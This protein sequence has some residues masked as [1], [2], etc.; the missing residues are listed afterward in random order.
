MKR[1]YYN[2]RSHLNQNCQSPSK[3]SVGKCYEVVNEIN[4]G[5][6]TNYILKGL[7]DVTDFG[8]YPG[9]NSE[10]FKIV[11]VYQAI[12]DM[13]PEVGKQLENISFVDR[14]GRKVSLEVS[15]YKVTEVHPLSENMYEVYTL[16]NT[17]IVQVV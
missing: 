14:Y 15:S 8:E 13:I 10:C 2:G 3:L 1:V 12:S 9:F 6:Q 5:G 16:Y 4:I 17:Y 11:P 7:E